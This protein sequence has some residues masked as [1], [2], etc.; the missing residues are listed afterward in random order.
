MVGVSYGAAMRVMEDDVLVAESLD[1][2]PITVGRSKRNR[3]CLPH[4]TVSRLHATIRHDGEGWV[5]E[6]DGSKNGTY[7]N[8]KRVSGPVRLAHGDV[9]LFGTAA[10][11]IELE[12]R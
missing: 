1:H 7:V 11:R 3:L 2:S 12:G 9:V 10:V 6:D 4:I 8:G 5:I